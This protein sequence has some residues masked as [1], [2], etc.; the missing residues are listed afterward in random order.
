M[1]FSL[2]GSCDLWCYWY[3]SRLSEGIESPL[4]QLG[5][6]I[7]TAYCSASTNVGTRTLKRPE[8]EYKWT[9]IHTS[10]SPPIYRP[11]H[12]R[13]CHKRQDWLTCLSTGVRKPKRIDF[14]LSVRIT[15]NS[16]RHLLQ[17]VARALH[18]LCRAAWC[19]R[20]G[21]W[22]PALQFTEMYLLYV[23]HLLVFIADADCSGSFST[24]TL[25]FVFAFMCKVTC[26]DDY[27]TLQRLPEKN[28]NRKCYGPRYTILCC[29]LKR[30]SKILFYVLFYCIV[31]WLA[32]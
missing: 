2:H 5:L 15:C 7:R 26:R 32:E 16:L 25:L 23:L 17:R 8:S 18:I 13:L 24:G 4:T 14:Y 6:H 20:R 31:F 21:V 29:K 28:A 30:H 19:K 1:C 11:Q 22:A 3:S 12:Q 27:Q 10:Y 9:Y